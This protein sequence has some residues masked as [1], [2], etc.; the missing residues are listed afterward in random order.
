MVPVCRLAD[1]DLLATARLTR[2]RHRLRVTAREAGRL[3]MPWLASMVQNHYRPFQV[4]IARRTPQSR[5][6]R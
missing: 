5:R 4:A 1:V 6:R 3:V 2:N